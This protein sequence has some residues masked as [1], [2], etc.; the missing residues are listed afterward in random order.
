MDSK[1]FNVKVWDDIVYV[2][3]VVFLHNA[4]RKRKFMSSNQL[5]PEAAETA[6]MDSEA[7]VW[8]T[9]GAGGAGGAISKADGERGLFDREE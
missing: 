2:C 3:V 4:Q 1:G 6:S 7:A 5:T 8:A 9:A